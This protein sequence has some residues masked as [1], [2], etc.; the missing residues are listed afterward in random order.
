MFP[1]KASAKKL[2]FELWFET[3]L[4]A[5]ALIGNDYTN[6]ILRIIL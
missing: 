6:I 5:L 1:I 4:S 2:I 3:R